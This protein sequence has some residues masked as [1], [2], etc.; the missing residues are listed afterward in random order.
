MTALPTTPV[1]Q[2]VIASTWGIAVA[3]WITTLSKLVPVVE[4]IATSN[5]STGVEVSLGETFASVDDY[6]VFHSWQE[7]QGDGSG[8]IVIEKS[9]SSFLIKNSGLTTGKKIAYWVM[10]SQA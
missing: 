10:R 2:T 8:D 6:R 5:G 7:D 4:G 1:T 3:A 9:A